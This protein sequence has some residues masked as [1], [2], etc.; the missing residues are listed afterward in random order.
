MKLIYRATDDGD[1]A[2]MFHKKCDN[3]SPLLILIK[4]TK[5]RRFGGFTQETFESCEKPKGKLDGSPFIFSLDKLKSYDVQE[6]QNAICSFKS[7]GPIFFMGM[8]LVIYI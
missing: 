2:S 3:L 8:N 1:T 4:T 5:H 7:N 6:G